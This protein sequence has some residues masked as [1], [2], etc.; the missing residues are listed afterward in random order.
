MTPNHDESPDTGSSDV[1]VRLRGATAVGVGRRPWIVVGVLAL[2]LS[3]VVLIVSL[4]S[5]ANDNARVTRLKSRGIAVSVT[6][7][8]CTGNLGGSGSNA[9]SYTCSG[10]YRVKATTYHETIG[11]MSAFT[12]PG[13]HVAGVADPSQPSTVVLASSLRSASASGSVFVIPGVLVVLWIALAG[14]FIN[15]LRRHPGRAPSP[16]LRATP[17]FGGHP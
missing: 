13:T 4:A 9:A 14:L 1:V 7:A 3:A 15:R 12:T 8:S 2:A 16:S 10:T 17:P 6:V 11:S 5:A